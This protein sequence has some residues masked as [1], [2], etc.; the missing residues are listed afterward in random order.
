MYARYTIRYLSS[1]ILLEAYCVGIVQYN[2]TYVYR[3]IVMVYY[4]KLDNAI[5]LE[6]VEQETTVPKGMM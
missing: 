1:F 5:C 6:F 4:S 3:I 2:G